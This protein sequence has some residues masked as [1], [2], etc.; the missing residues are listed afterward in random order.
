MS[1]KYPYKKSNS[2]KV[3]QEDYRYKPS[4]LGK[5]ALCVTVPA[6]IIGVVSIIVAFILM[7]IAAGSHVGDFFVICLIAE[8]VA[9]VGGI[10]IVVD[11]VISNNK[12]KKKLEKAGVIKEE[13]KEKDIANLIHFLVGLGL[14][15]LLGF[16][17]WGLI[18]E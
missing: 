9:F 7:A 1:N 14:G 16:L 2:Y 8:A 3:Q 10:V 17:K 11:I 4:M 12:N 6:A 15:I 18:K 13:K 5:I